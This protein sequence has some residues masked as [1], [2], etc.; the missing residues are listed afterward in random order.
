MTLS[1]CNELPLL[2]RLMGAKPSARHRAETDIVNENEAANLDTDLL[3]RIAAGDR[4]AFA[5]FYD[6]HSTLMYS[7]ACKILDD[8][9]EAQDVL[10]EVFAQIWERAAAFDP[11]QGKASSWVA[12]LVRNRSIDRIRASQRRLRLA[13]EAETH[14]AVTFEDSANEKIFGHDKAA[15]IQKAIAALPHEQR[16]AV[17]L[18]YFGGLTQMEI[19]EKLSEPLGTIKARIRRALLKLRDQL[20]GRL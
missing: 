19:S 14:F 11:D 5:D 10:Q 12:T 4:T 15:L 18:A 13:G 17:E 6:R 2:L 3:R 7:I 20:E 9:A 8:A 1:A 16:Q